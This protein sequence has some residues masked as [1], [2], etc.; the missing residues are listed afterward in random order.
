MIGSLEVT[1]EIIFIIHN[2][3]QISSI[4]W[5]QIRFNLGKPQLVGKNCVQRF[6]LSSIKMFTIMG[7]YFEKV[8][9]NKNALQ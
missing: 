8:T 1:D 7:A 5:I 6:E 2:V 3:I 4:N 9:T